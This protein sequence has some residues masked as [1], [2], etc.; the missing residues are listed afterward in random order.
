MKITLEHEDSE[1]SITTQDE[2]HI[3]EVIDRLVIP[4]LIAHG[5]S[6]KLLSEYIKSD[7]WAFYGN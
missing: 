4:V 3:S 5:F 6:G 7:M 2:A 1:V